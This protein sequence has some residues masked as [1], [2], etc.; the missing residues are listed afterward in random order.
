MRYLE[1]EPHLALARYYFDRGDRLLA[2]Y[3]SEAARQGRF[4]EKIFDPAFFR[5]FA[6]FDNSKAAEARLL[7]EYSRHPHS[8]DTIDALADIYI[9][10]EDWLN[11]KR[12]LREAIQKKPEDYR[13][14]LELPKVLDRE[15]KK[16]ESAQLTNDYVK[17]FPNSAATFSIR[18]EKLTEKQ[19]LEARRIIAEGL[20]LFPNDGLLLFDLG[21][22]YQREDRQ[23]AEEALVKA[24]ELSPKS[25]LIQ[26]WVGRFF[27]KVKADNSRA[28]EYYLNAYFINPH[29]YETEFVESRIRKIAYELATQKVA[30]QTKRGVSLVSLLSDP[31]PAV[32]SLAL[33]QMGENWLPAYVAPVVQLTGHPDPGLRAEAAET[34]KT[35][36]DSSFDA[37]LKALLADNDLPKRGL[38]IYIAV[39]RWKDKSFGLVR[40]LL[41]DESQ[42]IRFDAVSALFLEGGPAGRRLAKAHG[43]HEPNATL[44]KLIEKAASRRPTLSETKRGAL[45]AS[46]DS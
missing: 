45:S 33:E 14:T 6:G 4:E 25:E 17:N 1:P 27:F 15:G 38:A 36:V 46:L 11:A 3:I 9:S 16:Q 30:E 5:V 28:L 10:R 18:A 37:Q 34:L 42:L 23:K 12:Y 19:P 41:K 43:V 40:N 22:T 8:I 2:F 13:F 20:K 31:N 44:K 21:I 7:A 24:A 29:A 32:V 26:T 39:Y 35:R